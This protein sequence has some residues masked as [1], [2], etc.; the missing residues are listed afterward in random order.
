MNLYFTEKG[1]KKENNFF[2][3]F[4]EAMKGLDSLDDFSLHLE[5]NPIGEESSERLG[6]GL[7]LRIGQ[8]KNL[9]LLLNQTEPGQKG[10][11]ALVDAFA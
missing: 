4:E 8:L 10:Q 7:A 1:I 3:S 9:E 5:E 2:F 6:R 11:K